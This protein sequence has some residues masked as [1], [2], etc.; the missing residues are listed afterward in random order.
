MAQSVYRLCAWF[1]QLRRCKLQLA[2][3]LSSWTELSSFTVRCVSQPTAHFKQV[4][5]P[6]NVRAATSNHNERFWRVCVVLRG[7]A[8]VQTR[9]ILPTLDFENLTPEFAVRRQNPPN[10]AA[11]WLTGLL[12]QKYRFGVYLPSV[13]FQT[14]TFPIKLQG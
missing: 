4:F 8:V 11:P 10:V 9:R 13:F 14:S 1:D 7:V 2:N 12:K 5:R 6:E 3:N